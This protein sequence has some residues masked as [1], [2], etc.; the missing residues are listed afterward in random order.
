MVAKR[1]IRIIFLYEFKK[2]TSAAKTAED[3]NIVFGEGFVNPSTAQRWFKRFREGNEDLDNENRGR[4]ASVVDNDHL[5]TIIEADSQQTVKRISEDLGVSKNTVCRHLKQIGKT[6]NCLEICSSLLLRNKNDSF[7]DRIVTCDEKWILYDNRKRAGQWLDKDEAPK[8]FSKPQITPKKMIV[9]V[10]WSS[11]GLILF[12]KRPSLVNRKGPILLHDNTRPHV[13]K[14]TLYK[15]ND[16]KYETLA[17][18]PYFPD[19]APTDFHFFKNLDQFLKDKVFKYEESIKIAFEE[20]IV[21]RG[22][23]FYAN[24]I[25]KLVPPQL[26]SRNTSRLQKI[27]YYNQ[28]LTGEQKLLIERIKKYENKQSIEEIHEKIIQPNTIVWLKNTST[29]TTDVKNN[30]LFTEPFKVSK[31]LHYNTYEITNLN[32]KNKI[33]VPLD[34]L[35]IDPNQNREDYGESNMK[36]TGRSRKFPEESLNKQLHEKT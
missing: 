13:L 31:R 21:S 9:T 3:I 26:I 6:K 36:R 1:E 29:R 28:N 11:E 23:N 22:A 35:K 19:L 24:G 8:Q 17:H 5:R 15:L 18:L 2:G 7:L 16:L 25:N 10:W 32:E 14:T 20:F 34:L 12:K 30:K 4:P 33:K 27:P